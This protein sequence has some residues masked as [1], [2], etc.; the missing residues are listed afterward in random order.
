MFDATGM[1][2]NHQTPRNPAQPYTLAGVPLL[3]PGFGTVVSNAVIAVLAT[4][5]LAG[6]HL[7]MGNGF[8]I[9]PVYV[10][11]VFAG[12]MIHDLGFSILVYP[13]QAIAAYGVVLVM[14]ASVTVLTS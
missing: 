13:V 14:A 5:V 2:M 11:I 1:D 4:A 10:P 7:L 9:E 6:L 8:R 12:L 3:R